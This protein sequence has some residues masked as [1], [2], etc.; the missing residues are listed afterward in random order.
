MD[1]VYK[2]LRLICEKNL[3][4]NELSQAKEQLKGHIA[5][6]LDSNLELMF[7]LG[8]SVMIHGKVDTVEQIYEQIDSIDLNEIGEMANRSFAAHNCAELIYEF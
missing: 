6:A 1:L 3:T 8:M 5:L 2:E 4:E 7:N